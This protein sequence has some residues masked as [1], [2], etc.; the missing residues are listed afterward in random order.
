MRKRIIDGE[1]CSEFAIKNDL[2]YFKN[3]L[4]S[5]DDSAIIPKILE[6]YHSSVFGGH[7]GVE[8]WTF[9]RIRNVFI[10]KGMKSSTKNFVDGCVSK[11][12]N[13]YTAGKRIIDAIAYSGGG[14]ARYQYGFRYW[15]A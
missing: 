1:L 12:E 10:W 9:H 13:I 6:E 3:R 7:S 2:I 15:F 4:W 5:V 14:M 11:D 8:Y